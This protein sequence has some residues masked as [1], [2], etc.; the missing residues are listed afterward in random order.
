MNQ[1]HVARDYFLKIEHY[2][3]DNNYLNEFSLSPVN[4]IK[5]SNLDEKFHDELIKIIDK[6]GF[7]VIDLNSISNLNLENLAYWQEKFLGKIFCE[8]NPKKLTYCKV[9]AMPNSKYFVGSSFSQPLHTDE[10]YT[11]SYPKYI[12]LYCEKQA[13]LGGI[14]TLVDFLQIYPKL[15]LKFKNTLHE[16]EKEDAV[17]VNSIIGLEKKPVL[18]FDKKTGTPGISYCAT[19]KEMYCNEQTFKIFD[20]ITNFIHNP[21]NQIRFQLNENQLLIINNSRMLHGRTAFDDNEPRTLYRF[22]FDICHL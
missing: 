20:Y 17:V 8:K 1:I 14:S 2:V 15:K 7:V 11:H 9:S 19:L 18:F 21:K 6:Y 5:I 3:N 16:L 10:G 4:L 13:T 22:W 12:S